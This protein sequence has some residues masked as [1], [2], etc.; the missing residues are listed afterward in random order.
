MQEDEHER[1]ED[2]DREEDDEEN[3]EQANTPLIVNNPALDKVQPYVNDLYYAVAHPRFAVDPVC[4][5]RQRENAC[6][7]AGGCW[8]WMT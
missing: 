7:A 6:A 4:L 5:R 8:A 1:W 3:R 2:A